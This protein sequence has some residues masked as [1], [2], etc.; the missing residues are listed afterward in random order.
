MG[1]YT[2]HFSRFVK[3]FPPISPYSHWHCHCLNLNRWQFLCVWYL[4]R[5]G[6][7]CF[8]FF[9]GQRQLTVLFIGRYLIRR[10]VFL[11]GG[12]VLPSGEVKSSVKI[13]A[14]ARPFNTAVLRWRLDQLSSSKLR[15]ECHLLVLTWAT[16]K[17]KHST[18]HPLGFWLPWPGPGI[19]AAGDAPGTFF[20]SELSSDAV[21]LKV[22][23]LKANSNL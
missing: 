12:C 18:Q 7:F 21:T 3:Q 8:G 14:W 5:S 1:H 17:R 22:K 10:L 16:K 20:G 6:Y 2:E 4:L 23:A 13:V 19:P 15:L 9:F 11:F